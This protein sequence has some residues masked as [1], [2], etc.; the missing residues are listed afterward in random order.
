MTLK[1]RLSGQMRRLGVRWSKGY[2]D[3][4]DGTR[5]AGWAINP[6]APD[7]PAGLTL[8]VD[9]KPE[10]A[11]FADGERRDVEASGLGPRYCGFDIAVPRHLL[12]RPH[13]LELRLNATGNLLRGGTLRLAGRDGKALADDAA[14]AEGVAFFDADRRQITGWAF[15]TSHVAIRLDHEPEAVVA[16][17]RGVA[18]FGPSVMAGFAFPVPDR[19]LDGQPHQ[20]RVRFGDSP[21]ELDGSPLSF[22]CVPAPV[23]V[24]LV[25]FSDG[26]AQFL[27]RDA[28]GL[29][30]A[31]ALVPRVDGQPVPAQPTPQGLAV[32]VPP[33]AA[34]VTVETPA[35]QVL[36]HFVQ[37]GGMLTDRMQPAT[38]VARLAAPDVLAL[39]GRAFAAFCQ[40]PD[41]RF[42]PLWYRQADPQAWD[43]DDP[44]RLIA[45][46]RNSGAR[47]G[48]APNGF[49]DE[50]GLRNDEPALAALVD[51]GALP[52]LFALE[53]ALG[54]E[55]L[56][57]FSALPPHL[58]A[59]LRDGGSGVEEQAALI[60]RLTT[61]RRRSPAPAQDRSSRDSIYAAWLSRLVAYPAQ[62][63]EIAADDRAISTELAGSALKAEPLVSIIMP[64]WN[65]AFTIGEAIQSVLEQSY[66]NWELIICDDASKDRTPEVVHRFDDPRIRYNRFLKSN[67]AGARNKGLRFARGEFIAYLDSDNIW[68]PCFL[69]LMLRRLLANPGAQMAYGGFLDTEIDGATVR[70]EAITRPSF[71]PIPLSSKNFIDLNG[72]VHHRRLYDWLGG[73]DNN[74]PRLQDWDLVLR[75]TSVFRPLFVGRIGVFYRRNVAWGQVTH[76]FIGSNAASVVAEKTRRRLAGDHVRLAL[77]GRGQARLTVLPSGDRHGQYRPQDLILA[78]HLAQAAARQGDVDLLLPQDCP[79]RPAPMLGLTLHLLPGEALRDGATLGG[80]VSDRPVLVVGSGAPPGDGFFPQLG[81]VL[82]SGVEGGQLRNLAEPRAVFSLGPVPL[83]LPT[84]SRAKTHMLVLTGDGTEAPLLAGLAGQRMP[85]LI[86]PTGAEGW[87]TGAGDGRLAPAPLDEQGLAKALADVAIVAALAIP[88]TLSPL[89]RALLA[90]CQAQGIPIMLPDDR[91]IRPDGF[92][93]QWIDANAA[94]PLPDPDRLFAEADRILRD[95][96]VLGNQDRQGRT[97]HAIADHPAL[98]EEKLAW[99]TLHATTETIRAEVTFDADQP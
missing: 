62:L 80:L 67:G 13:L 42:D 50:Q 25:E 21:V 30:T 89:S 36:A 76:L 92:A 63:D 72:I 7:E 85:L 88:E 84:P 48:I 28:M 4:F 33:D 56:P 77:P 46:Y 86:A 91:A 96:A 38:P 47:R 31:V 27:V 70:L 12:G 61:P 68:H 98:F 99:L 64:S 69:E 24:E 81:F 32:P 87:R 58:R 15:G 57:G 93:A 43:I 6:H 10:L 11:L 9:G 79:L 74:L 34:T 17:D 95:K 49:F 53:L 66:P 41:S 73:F 52:C 55:R 51:S 22:S 94:S 75:Y 23:L 14:Q 19:Y 3:R 5:L 20:V 65:R 18:G 26:I 45:L 39:A 97:C 54:E 78:L 1:S 2:I 40:R 59:A 71:R 16:L 83:S 60:A 37:R 8:Y 35:G 90:A 44:A 82:E 29:V